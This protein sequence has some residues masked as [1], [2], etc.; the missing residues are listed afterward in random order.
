MPI[1]KKHKEQRGKNFLLLGV[2]IAF[3]AIIYYVTVL[4]LGG[5]A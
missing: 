5:G 2:L 3:L 1:G 4:K